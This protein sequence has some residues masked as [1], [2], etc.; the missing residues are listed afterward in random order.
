MK[1]VEI[2]ALQFMPLTYSQAGSWF[3]IVLIKK[4]QS[5]LKEIQ[6]FAIKSKTSK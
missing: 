1:N 4:E 2:L 3:E 6:D 5:K